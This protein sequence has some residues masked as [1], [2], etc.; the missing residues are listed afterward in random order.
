MHSLKVLLIEPHPYRLMALHQMLNAYG[1][2]D[3][4]VAESDVQARGV[5]AR[6]GPVDIAI[7]DPLA[8]TFDGV[9]LARDLSLHAL[10]ASLIILSGA[11]RSVLEGAVDLLEQSGLN[12]LGALPTPVCPQALHR[13]LQHYLVTARARPQVA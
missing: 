11:R 13:C 12:V 6:R 2:Y 8:S 7:C 9:G 10:S 3:V 5:L 4:R 1:V